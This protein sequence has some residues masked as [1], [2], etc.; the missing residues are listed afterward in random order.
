[1]ARKKRGRSR[2][3]ALPLLLIF[4]GI[5]FLGRLLARG[6]DLEKLNI[7]SHESFYENL[8]PYAKKTGEKYNLYPSMILAQAALESGYGESQLAIKYNNLFGMKATDGKGVSLETD[9]IIDGKRQTQQEVF[10][11]YKDLDH[12]FDAY[13]KLLGTASRYEKV[14]QAASLDEALAALDEAGYSTNPH[15]GDL[16]R[17]LIEKDELY[18]YDED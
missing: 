17:Q 7:D 4:L 15:Y 3:C 6:K 1:M 5:F 10:A 9:E 12:T 2:G 14:T 16:L 18:T 13:G 8:A 11:V